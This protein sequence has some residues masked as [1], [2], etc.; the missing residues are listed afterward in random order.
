M[1][2]HGKLGAR[3]NYIN[4]AQEMYDQGGLVREHVKWEYELRDPA[5]VEDVVDRAVAIACSAPHLLLASLAPGG[6]AVCMLPDSAALRLSSGAKESACASSRPKR[7]RISEK[8]RT[9]NQI[10][11]I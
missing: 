3:N 2:E 4:W 10:S 11:G 8:A 6:N 9:Y 5:Q 7:W 1:L